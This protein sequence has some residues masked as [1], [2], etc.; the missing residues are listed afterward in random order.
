VPLTL[1]VDG[2]A[3]DSHLDRFAA[4][5]P[6]IIPVC[7]GN[8]YGFGLPRVLERAAR[9]PGVVTVAVGTMSELATVPASG[10][11]SGCDVLVLTP[12]PTAEVP[13]GG[14][15]SERVV[16][17]A[18]T[19]GDVEVA[20]AA[21]HRFVVECR[22]DLERHGVAVEDLRE[23]AALLAR[24]PDRRELLAGWGLH[25]PLARPGT[26]SGV[27]EA[28]VGALRA[29]GLEPATVHVSHLS[30]GELAALATSLPG[31]R[32][33]PRVGTD[34][35]LGDRGAL[36]PTATVLDVHHL[37]RG[38]PAGYW[39]RRAPGPG[40]VVVAAGG[41]THGIGLTAPPPPTTRRRLGALRTAVGDSTG[42]ARSPFVLD[43]VVLDFF[44][45]P[46]MQVSLLW[47]PAAGA[48]HR[49]SRPSRPSEPPAPP[50]RGTEL[51]VR[52]RYT[53]TTFDR[54]VVTG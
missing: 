14:P 30:V 33:R 4:A 50:A 5:R 44:E 42:R 45:P 3:W 41:T 43:G 24:H 46:H 25:L 1:T 28:R 51:T 18:S 12:D 54:V 9:L 27:V 16:R 2:R 19:V 52:V 10:P 7:K 47:L 36:V 34:L 48:R 15:R 23:L 22:T 37:S 39:Q 49:P 32:L 17:T 21:G 38:A 8:G 40:W 35:W 20:L 13:A 31:T 53:T 29:A 11:A 6:G 26:W